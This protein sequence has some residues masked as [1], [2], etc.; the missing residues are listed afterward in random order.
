[1]FRDERRC[2]IW[3]QIRQHGLQ[4]FF[5][6]LPAEAFVNAAQVAG[7]DVGNS[8]LALPT[9]VMLALSAAIHRTKSF[10]DVLVFTL[11]LLEDSEHWPQSPLAAARNNAKRRTKNS[12]ERRKLTKTRSKHNPCGN[13]P[14]VVTEEAF[15]QARGRMPLR[16]WTAL[17]MILVC[18]FQQRH[19]KWLQWN[20]F[21][22]LAIDGTT[23]SMQNWKALKGHFGS[24]KNGKSERAQARM[25]ML[26]FPMARMPL[27]YELTPLDE[28]ERVVAE[29]L[30]TGLEP[31]DLVLMDQGFWSYKLFWQIQNQNAYFAIRRNP[32]AQ[33]KII[34]RLGKK[35]RIVEWAPSDR[36]QRHGL[37]PVIRLREVDYQIKGFRAS[38]VV[39][40]VLDPKRISREQW[41]RLATQSDEG[42]L[43]L[44]QGLYHRRWEIETTFAELKVTQG[45]EGSL[46]SR[47]PNG[48]YYEVAGH[49]LLYLLIRWLIVEAAEAEGVDPLRISFKGAL[50]ELLDILPSL[51]VASPRRIAQV[52]LPRLLQRIA[53]HRVPFR[54]G[55]FFKRP[56]DGKNKYKYK[57]KGKSKTKPPNKLQTK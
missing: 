44:V 25:V 6:L 50:N 51:T 48:I 38:T 32:G 22:L 31:D 4:A 24:A 41:V 1:M 47:K 9:L 18:R 45:M 43:R 20:E 10:G 28:G 30:L 56:R 8:A 36:D 52:L 57:R 33:F 23:V 29:R 14:T 19:A 54:P 42:R 26:Q 35:D 55:R 3:G 13:D 21:R 7:V 17:L 12:K 37:P 46:R 15:V 11:K 53:S 16:F 49:V 40:N 2:K 39:T 34:K 27:R 5:K